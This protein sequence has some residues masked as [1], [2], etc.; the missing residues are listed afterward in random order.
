MSDYGN[1][2]Y[3][4]NMVVYLFLSIYYPIYISRYFKL[5]L[6]NPILVIFLVSLPVALFKTF[7]GPLYALDNGLFNPY[8]NYALLMT[9]LSLTIE[10]IM[11]S[12]LLKTFSNRRIFYDIIYA[13][14]PKWK[15]SRKKMLYVSFFFLLLAGLF[16]FLLAS[17]SFGI[18]NWL[19]APR[20]GYQ[21]HRTGAGQYFAFSLLCLSASYAISLLY[22]K[23]INTVFILSAVYLFFVWFLGSK[24]FMLNFCIC[25]FIVLWFRR[26]RHL[27]RALKLGV[28]FIFGLL[29]LNFGSFDLEKI[30]SYFDYYINSSM[31]YE[32]YLKGNIDLF[33]G[34]IAFSQFWGLIPR[35]FYPDKPYVYGFLLVNEYFFPGAAEATNTPAF[36]GPIA[37][38]A[39]FGIVGVL[40]SSIFNFELGFRVYCYYVIFKD[41]SY[42]KIVSNPFILY[43]FLLLFAPNFLN[44]FAFPLSFIVFLVIVKTV[45]F[46]NRAVIRWPA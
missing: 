25:S 26:Y 19:K 44:F 46:F 35:A 23:K 2:L 4:L 18:V 22:V 34:E 37:A 38:F 16:F 40:F 12:L 41:W 13:Y 28:P 21:L 9:N 14:A 17:H 8:F 32:E 1:A 6:L 43:V 39:D 30:T 31:Y 24:G 36:G 29:L 3:V 10:F 33:Y 7:V 27:K 20:V 45:G 11:T 5:S 42:E 15:V